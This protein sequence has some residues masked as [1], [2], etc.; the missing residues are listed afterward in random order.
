MIC[1]MMTARLS[2]ACGG[3]LNLR[4]RRFQPIL[5]G[6]HRLCV[7]FEGNENEHLYGMGQYQMETLDIQNCTFELAQ[8]NSQ[9]SVP[10]VMSSRGYGFLWHNP[11]IGEAHFGSNRSE[12]KAV[13]T[14]QMDYW[15]TAGDSPAELS[16]AY[17]KAT[18]FAPMLPDTESYGKEM[19]P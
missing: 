1:R 16:L 8:R 6:D 7:S 4:A 17:A 15:I 18:G 5:G 2:A 9:A 3:A 19:I 11:A 14:R 13:S 10:F 12:W